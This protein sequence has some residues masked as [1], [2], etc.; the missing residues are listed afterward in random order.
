MGC[1]GSKDEAKSAKKVEK[2]SKLLYR[3][4]LFQVG[5]WHFFCSCLGQLKSW[6]SMSRLISV[7]ISSYWRQSIEE[8]KKPEAKGAAIPEA[9][10]KEDKHSDKSPKASRSSS[11]SM[12]SSKSDDSEDKAAK[13]AAKKAKKEAKKAKKDKSHSK[14]DKSDSD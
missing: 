6:A 11:S 14:S 7:Q 2:Q 4:R 1:T 10:P 5:S 12:S 9:K 8:A 3:D 13:K